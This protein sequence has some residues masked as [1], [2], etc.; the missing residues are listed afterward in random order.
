MSV[1]DDVS[2]ASGWLNVIAFAN[3]ALISVT[4]DVSH[5]SGWL[6]IVAHRNILAMLVTDDVSHASGWVIAAHLSI[7]SID[8]TI[9]ML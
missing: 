9:E 8:V 7:D 1:T 2:H 3:I 5:A 6:N 4:D